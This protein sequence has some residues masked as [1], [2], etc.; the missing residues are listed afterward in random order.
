MTSTRDTLARTVHPQPWSPPRYQI[1]GPL[2]VACG[3]HHLRPVQTCSFEDTPPPTNT[4]IWWPKLMQFASRWYAS[5]WN[6]SCLEMNYIINNHFR[7]LS[8]TKL[9]TKFNYLQLLVICMGKPVFK[10]SR[11]RKFSSFLTI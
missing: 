8:S 7:Q 9:A 4:D 6:F 5:Y 3:G 10:L 2:L 11:N 1:W